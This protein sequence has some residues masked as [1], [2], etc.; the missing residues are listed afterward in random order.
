M[1]QE[2]SHATRRNIDLRD[3]LLNSSTVD[4]YERS[5]DNK[6][7]TRDNV[8]NPERMTVSYATPKYESRD[9]KGEREFNRTMAPPPLPP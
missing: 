8:F 3:T 4:L 6:A 5:T 1:N 9:G 2:L 7:L